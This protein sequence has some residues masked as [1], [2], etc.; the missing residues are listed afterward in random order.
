MQR[1]RNYW[2]PNALTPSLPHTPSLHPP[3][4]PPSLPYASRE[5]DCRLQI[6]AGS[7]AMG[8][9]GGLIQ[10]HTSCIK[11]IGFASGPPGSNSQQPPSSPTSPPETP[12][13]SDDDDD[14]QDDDKQ[15]NHEHHHSNEYGTRAL[16]GV[17]GFTVAIVGASPSFKPLCTLT[18]RHGGRQRR[19]RSGRV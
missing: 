10:T 19:V 8:F 12:P 2:T 17:T 14:D 13:S 15:H 9:L 6:A 7:T 3:P 1:I 16:L 11:H 4:L 5:Q 18:Q